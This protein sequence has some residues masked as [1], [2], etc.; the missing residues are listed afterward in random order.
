MGRPGVQIEVEHRTSQGSAG[1]KPAAVGQ[2]ITGGDREMIDEGAAGILGGSIGRACAY[3]RVHYRHATNGPTPPSCRLHQHRQ[4]HQQRQFALLVPQERKGAVIQCHPS[5]SAIE[6]KPDTGEAQIAWASRRTALRA[7]DRRG[8]A[9]RR[10]RGNAA[11]RLP[12][13]ATKSASAERHI[14]RP[15]NSALGHRRAEEGE[16]KKSLFITTNA[17]NEEATEARNGTPY[18]SCLVHAIEVTSSESL[19]K[20]AGDQ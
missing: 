13:A 4:R 3:R 6:T 16:S 14:V 20:V 15:F 9:W 2:R 10:R 11:C 7:S 1:R 17:A 12:P 5:V 18:L 19:R 8:A